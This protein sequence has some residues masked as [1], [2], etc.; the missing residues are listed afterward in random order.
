[1]D[2]IPAETVK[3]TWKRMAGVSLSE[4]QKMVSR[5]SKEQ[6][7]VVTYLLTAG[8]DL[9]NEDERGLLFYVG[10]VVWQIMLQGDAPLP[11]VTAAAL[12]EAQREN[13]GMLESL[14][15]RSFSEVEEAV[16]RMLND[17]NQQEVLSYVVEAL[18]EE[19]EEGCL[20]RE[21]NTGLMMLFLKT[22][23]D[24]FD[25]QGREKQRKRRRRPRLTKQGERDGGL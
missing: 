3:K 18:T 9:L 12:E 17:Y 14:A 13:M 21:E 7:A 19:P 24:C 11:R 10:L 20:I 15:G 23:I 22:V 16:V 1:M 8:K 5:M 25:H 2:P 4:G 6:P